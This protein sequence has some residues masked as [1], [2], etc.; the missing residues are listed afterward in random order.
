MATPANVPDV[1]KFAKSALSDGSEVYHVI[2]RDY[3]G[4]AIAG[5][6][7]VTESEAIELLEAINMLAIGAF[8]M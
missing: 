2:I 8:D 6:E 1:A 4:N 7:A 3:H 5:I